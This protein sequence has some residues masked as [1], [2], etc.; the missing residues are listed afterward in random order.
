MRLEPVLED[1]QSD[2]SLFFILRDA[3]PARPQRTRLARFLRAGFPRPRTQPA[4]D[5][6]SRLQS[7]GKSAVRLYSLCHLPTT[8]GTEPA[9]GCNQGRR[10]AVYA[11]RASSELTPFALRFS[12]PGNIAGHQLRRISSEDAAEMHVGY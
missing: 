9:S 12:E 7:D 1:T 3:P 11:L 6:D 2:K 5:S 10:E 4:G 8:A